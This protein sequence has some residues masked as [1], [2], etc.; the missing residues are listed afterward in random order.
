MLQCL[1]S[2]QILLMISTSDD[3]VLEK[4]FPMFPVEKKILPDS[5]TFGHIKI[6]L[7]SFFYSLH[8]FTIFFYYLLNYSH[9]YFAYLRGDVP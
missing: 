4:G 6:T 8:C 7:A 9:K 2:G 5:M 3:D 1:L